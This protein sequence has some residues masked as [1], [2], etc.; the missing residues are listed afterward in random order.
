MAR[1]QI[2]EGV[3][4]HGTSTGSLRITLPY[5]AVEGVGDAGMARQYLVSFAQTMWPSCVTF[6]CSPGAPEQACASRP[7]KPHFAGNGGSPG[8]HSYTSTQAPF[9][10]VDVFLVCVPVWAWSGPDPAPYSGVVH[11]W[12]AL[13][14]HQLISSPI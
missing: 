6:H 10:G 11:T 5:R 14:E 2:C 1:D 13:F 4:A 7:V 12:S 8:V 3:F 9:D